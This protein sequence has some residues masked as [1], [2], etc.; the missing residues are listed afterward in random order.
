[1]ALSALDGLAQEL[2]DTTKIPGLAVAVARDGKVVFARGYGVRKAG[3]PER[4]DADTV[5]QIASMSKSIG[6]SV[7]AHQVGVNTIRWDT[8]VIKHLPWFSLNDAW[9]TRHLTIGDLYAHRSGLPDHAGDELEDL[10]YDRRQVLERL[11]FLALDPFRSTYAYTN[12]GVTAAAEAVAAAAGTDWATLAEQVIYGPLGMSSTS[13]RFSDYIGRS[14]RAVPHVKAGDVY[15]ADFQRQP[16]AQSPAGG[17]SSTANDIG[18]WMA[19]VLQKGQYEGRQI[20]HPD[21]LLQAVTPQIVSSPAY[22][23]DARAGFYGYGFGISTQPSGRTTI[24]HSGAFMLG[25]ATNYM[26]IPS[27]NIGIAVL[28][29]A[30]PMGAVEA[31]AMEFA[32]LVQY[33]RSTRDWVS[34]Y[35]DLFEPL[36]APTG[37]LV[38]RSPPSNPS[39]AKDL[40]LYTGTYTNDYFGDAIIVQGSGSELVLKIGP[41]QQEYVLTHWD[42]D[43]FTFSLRNENANPGTVS[44]VEFSGPSQNMTTVTI[45]YF[46]ANGLGAFTRH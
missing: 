33:G 32:D 28:S 14:N 36:L 40:P 31:L 21:A 17:V 26:L 34:T 12:F 25:A 30:A 5:F 20:I 2:L 6:A 19:M 24:S 3:E 41:A 4:V 29:N 39:P 43:R 46:N 18:R 22:A 13:S 37:D 27:A 10:G 11:R 9:V 44:K 16:D 38:G 35:R 45:E 42:G 1:M 23:M 8:P 15:K 7:V